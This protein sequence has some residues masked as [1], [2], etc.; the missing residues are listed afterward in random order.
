MA[1]RNTIPSQKVLV[2]GLDRFGGAA[3]IE[4]KVEFRQDY[5]LKAKD[6]TTFEVVTYNQYDVTYYPNA[7]AY[8][9]FI[10]L[11]LRMDQGTSTTG[12]LYCADYDGE[13]AG[14]LVNSVYTVVGVIPTTAG[15]DTQMF[16]INEH[17][18]DLAFNDTTLVSVSS[19]LVGSDHILDLTPMFAWANGN[20][21]LGVSGLDVDGTGSTWADVLIST[22]TP[23]ADAT[24]GQ[25]APTVL[26][27]SSPAGSLVVTPFDLTGS[28]YTNKYLVTNTGTEKDITVKVRSVRMGV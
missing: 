7:H 23:A 1:T 5:E 18:I 8:T 14:A 20:I 22:I 13:P 12:V 3:E 28:Y 27:V 15:A 25:G 17:R 9:Q 11:I 6:N 2:K 10:P 4:A 19:A 21:N 26:S 16:A 24:K